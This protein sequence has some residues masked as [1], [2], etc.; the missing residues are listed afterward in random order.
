MMQWVKRNHKEQLVAYLQSKKNDDVAFNTFRCL[1]LRFA[2]KHRF[3]ERLDGRACI[4][5]LVDALF[6]QH[7]E[8]ASVLMLDNLD[9]HMLD[10]AHDKVAEKLFSVIEPL[11]ANSTSRCQPLVVEIMGPLKSMLKTAWLMEDEERDVVILRLRKNS[12]R[13][14]KVLS[15]MP[16]AASVTLGIWSLVGHKAAARAVV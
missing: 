6:G 16:L 11:P 1:L 7:I 8:D 5:N 9:C 4:V 13:S 3:R 15:E 2:Q 14:I 12:W 10:E